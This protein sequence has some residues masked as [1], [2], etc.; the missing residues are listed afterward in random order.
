MSA[1]D[2]RPG[3]VLIH[4]VG[5]DASMWEPVIARLD[6]GLDP[7][8]YDMIGHGC[9]SKPPGPYSLAAFVDQLM[10]RIDRVDRCR[11]QRFDVVGF[12]M[13]ALVAEGFALA[14]PARVRRLVLVGAVFDRSPAERA[15]IIE[16]VADV[17]NNGF[18]A[19]FEAALLRWFTPRFAASH[20]EVVARVRE[21][22]AAND[23]RAYAD[24]YEVFA[25]AD[26]ELAAQ[27]HRITQPT[28]VV[29]G[30]NDP[31]S[32]PAMACALAARLGNGRVHVVEGARHLLPLE[33]PD[34][35]AALINDFLGGCDV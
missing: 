11:G 1:A 17:R 29:T 26:T 34:T 9:A 3:V 7:F 21:C 22:L 28:L 20:P 23:E 33:V 32:T 12:S 30:A 10:D 19:G 24:A 13:G 25:T 14:N 16:R 35:L 27:L 2:A 5:L 15:A 8:A 4:G 6:A 18:A 31:R